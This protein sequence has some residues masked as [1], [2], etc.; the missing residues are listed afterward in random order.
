M[1]RLTPHTQL[2][3]REHIL[4]AAERCFLGKGFHVSTMNDICREAGISPGAL[5]LYF[6]S[7]DELILGLCEREKDR[8]TRD[9]V[10]LTGV[11]DFLS[12]LRSMAEHYC[13]NEPRDKARL[14]VE[15]AAEASRNQALSKKLR[16][17]DED[18]LAS[19]A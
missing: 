3:K 4:A 9:L 10:H 14:H 5:Y 11:A 16:R 17:M 13:C 19:F 18:I 6:T 12:A 1:P 15:S 8:F 7:K 2:E